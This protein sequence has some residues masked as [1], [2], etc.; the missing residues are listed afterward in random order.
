MNAKRRF[1]NKVAVVT[2]GGSGIGKE[3]ARR[4]VL[5]GGSVV[6]NGL[7]K[8]KLDGAAGEIDSSGQENSRS[9]G[10]YCKT[11]DVVGTARDRFGGFVDYRHCST[12]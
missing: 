10:R 1:Q 11:I 5:E 4:F 6:I 8:Q 2:G 12:S 7:D 3:V 9:C